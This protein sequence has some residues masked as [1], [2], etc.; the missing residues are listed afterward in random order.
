MLFHYRTLATLRPHPAWSE[1]I[2]AAFESE[3]QGLS[4]G[5]TFS[6]SVLS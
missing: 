5:R 3:R 2:A 4:P 6:F 1:S